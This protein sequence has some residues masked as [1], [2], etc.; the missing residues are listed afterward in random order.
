MDGSAS[1]LSNFITQMDA[2]GGAE[3]GNDGLVEANEINFF[4][5]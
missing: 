2:A 3:S 5:N 4:G 1:L